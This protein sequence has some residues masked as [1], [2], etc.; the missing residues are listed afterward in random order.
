MKW[1][2]DDVLVKENLVGKDWHGSTVNE[3]G[4]DTQDHEIV[5]DTNQTISQ[6][7]KHVQY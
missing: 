2:I 3:D 1:C 6:P 7:R 4:V 5:M